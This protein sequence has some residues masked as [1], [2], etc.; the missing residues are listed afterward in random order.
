[1]TK[2]NDVEVKELPREIK[3]E[4]PIEQDKSN[5]HTKW[6]KVLGSKVIRRANPTKLVKREVCRPPP[7]P[8]D[9]PNSVNYEQGT[10]MKRKKLYKN[11]EERQEIQNTEEEGIDAQKIDMKLN[12][13]PR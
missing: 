11:Q 6:K 2:I 13:K 12:C 1:M 9:R 8:P 10:K 3:L 4:I 7:K 5:L